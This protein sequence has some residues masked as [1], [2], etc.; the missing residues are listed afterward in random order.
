MKIRGMDDR[1]GFSVIEVLVALAI[2][3]VIAMM[4]IPL[5]SR[6]TVLNFAGRE[7]SQAATLVRSTHEDLTQADFRGG[8][9]AVASGNESLEQ[10]VWAFREPVLSVVDED[11]ETPAGEW[12]AEADL[13]DRRAFWER[14][15]RVVQYNV[16]DVQDDYTLNNPL[17]STTDPQFVHLKEIRVDVQTR[18]DGGPLG[19]ARG[20]AVSRIRA[21]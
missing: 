14:E 3:F 5:F 4:L 17:P 2:L 21:F 9:L 19:P 6:A 1:R 13:A 8:R 16:S 18:R 7:Y 10:R 15:V 11:V 12:V 20:L